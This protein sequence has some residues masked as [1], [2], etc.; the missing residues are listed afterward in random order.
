MLGNL[1]HHVP[2]LV[3]ITV[4][5]ILAGG[6][7]PLAAAVFDAVNADKVDGKHAVGAGATAR[8]RAGK[9]VATNS[10][11]RLPNT[12][13]AKAP[14]ADRLDGRD[15]SAFQPRYA[16]TVIV[17]PVGNPD[18]NGL[19]LL[20]TLAN[21][22][23]EDGNN[24]A[25]PSASNRWLV[26]IEPGDY[27]FP[28]FQRL[29]MRGFVDVEGSGPGTRIICSCSAE[30]TEDFGLQ[31][32]AAVVGA[33]ST[34]L[35]DLTII[36]FGGEDGEEVHAIGVLN[37]P[38]LHDVAIEVWNAPTAVGV[39]TSSGTLD[40]TRSTIAV[41]GQKA[42]GLSLHGER[43]T[44]ADVSLVAV[45]D[46]GNQPSLGIRN[47]G[48]QTSVR[49]SRIEVGGIGGTM[50]PDVN[51][52][53]RVVGGTVVVGNSELTA[54]GASAHALVEDPGAAAPRVF[55][56]ASMLDGGISGWPVC[57]QSY[58]GAFSELDDDCLLP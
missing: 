16:R 57:A 49:G 23:P 27:V 54:Q 3:A 35:R 48:G 26:K 51:T 30:P 47:E 12:I 33:G 21:A 18:Q 7:A 6:G 24:P 37:Q 31:E 38:V 17:S 20:E 1:R 15:S 5:A 8:Q 40:L 34:E 43:H 4:T 28:P 32:A 29:Y 41:S 46:I 58:N 55:V 39:W 11:G 22:I 50:V 53:L 19:A 13:I 25:V 9:L 14:D 45:G 36:N 2:V 52:A 10:L 42:V 56:A 44:I